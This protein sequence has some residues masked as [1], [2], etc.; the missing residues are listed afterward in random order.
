[1]SMSSSTQ[2][3]SWDYS[4]TDMSKNLEN[5]LALPY[6]TVL[7]RDEEGDVVARVKELPGCVA[8][9]SDDLE[10]LEN[11]REV[12]KVWLEDC[13]ESGQRV[14]EPS[15]E[16]HLPS[17]KWLQR[18]PRTLHKRLTERAEIE[19]VSL[20]QL[21]TA[22]LSAALASRTSAPGAT[23]PDMCG[24]CPLN[25]ADLW[26]RVTDPGDWSF[27]GSSPVAR[28]SAA[29]SQVTRPTKAQHWEELLET[30]Q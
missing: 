14:P 2:C 13:L 23:E 29:R 8:H 19:G 7:R 9:G 16:E 11:L 22:M 1:M 6:T 28:S 12:Q 27:V 17:G 21:V 26:E 3:L 24:T 4:K 30:C 25:R 10:A 18:V 5:Y 15:V 20:N